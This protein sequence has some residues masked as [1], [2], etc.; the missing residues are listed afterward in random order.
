[1][2]KRVALI[3]CC[4]MIMTVPISFGVEVSGGRY[5]VGEDIPAGYYTFRIED[6]AT[7][8]T[9]WGAGYQDYDTNGGLLLNTILEDP[10][11]SFLAKVV[12]EEGNVVDF[13][14]TLIIEK[15]E[16]QDYSEVDQFTLGGGRYIIG[17]DIPAGYYTFRIEDGSAY[18]TLWGAEYQDYDTNGGLLLNIILEYPSNSFLNKVVLE[19]GNVVDFDQ[20]I[21]V[22][23]YVP[24]DYTG[25]NEFILA[26][27]RY[28]VGEDIPAGSYTIQLEGGSAY[29]TVWGAA[30]QDYNTNGGLLLNTVLEDTGESML[31]KVVLEEGNVIDFDASLNFTV[32]QGISFD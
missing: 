11:N 13:D 31:G 2:F 9:I 18:I 10:G 1:M 7:N 27:G 25:V 3:V 29:V 23:K 8:V 6:G 22:E 14:H 19:E 20:T 12:L 15:Y 30:Y 28:I 16:P 24:E 4:I 17:E 21:V 32:F 26:G 5:F